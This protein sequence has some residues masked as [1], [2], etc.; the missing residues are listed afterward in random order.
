MDTTSQEIWGVGKKVL[1]RFGCIYILLFTLPSPYGAIPGIS[2]IAEYYNSLWNS[3]G[4]WF[5]ESVLSIGRTINTDS[6]GSG[7]RLID[8]IHM[9]IYFLAAMFGTI[10]WSLSDRGRSNYEKIAYWFTVHL[11]YYMFSTLLTYGMAKVI[12]TQFPFPSIVRLLQPIGDA[13][14][15]GLVWTFMGFSEPY[16]IFAGVMEVLAALL[17]LTRRTT[18]LGAIVS[19]GVMTNVMM[20]NFSYDIPV[21]I[22]S[23]HLV[24]F[25]LVLLIP[26]IKR[27]INVVILNRAAKPR[28]FLHIF[29]NNI[30]QYAVYAIKI[31]F[32]GYVTLSSISS[33]WQRYQQYG[34][35]R[36]KPH[37]YGLWKV[38][39][40]LRNGKRVPPLITDNNRW[41]YLIMEYPG[42]ANVIRM[43][44]GLSRYNAETDTLKKT[45]NLKTTSGNN[46][47][48]FNYE[49]KFLRLLLDGENNA[50]SLYV[51]L[52]EQN[53]DNFMLT[54]RGFN[55]IQEYPYNR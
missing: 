28:E 52:S 20:M 29:T 13:S 34:P 2:I 22:F 16:T 17:F 43:N 50:D 35:N 54:R 5:G 9:L 31:L 46:L 49:K 7:D 25:S 10:V 23:T 27:L 41:R 42:Q 37:L 19:L 39:T 26:D 8:Y 38:E 51:Y 48:T 45:L 1:F 40:F 12:K 3:F 30:Q 47:Y 24:L 55:W 21:K 18:T 32:I 6:T 44:G 4:V 53:P 36:E 33:I 14:P 15:M 11:R